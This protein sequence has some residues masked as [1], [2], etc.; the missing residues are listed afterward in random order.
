[1]RETLH[2]LTLALA[3]PIAVVAVG[4]FRGEPAATTARETANA[5]RV[6][7]AELPLP[8]PER[9]RTPGEAFD[10][11][12]PRVTPEDP[13]PSHRRRALPNPS[14]P[15]PVD[16]AVDAGA[17]IAVAAPPSPPAEPG[18]TGAEP[19][20]S[21]PPVPSGGPALAAAAPAATAHP[22]ALVPKVASSTVPVKIPA[23]IAATAS[24][25]PAQSITASSAARTVAQSTPAISTAKTVAQSIIGTPSAQLPV[26]SFTR[27]SVAKLP[28]QLSPGNP[29]VKETTPV[30]LPST[31][32][33]VAMF[34]PAPDFLPRNSAPTFSSGPVSIP[35][36]AWG[37]ANAFPILADRF[38][39]TE[40]WQEQGGSPNGHAPLTPPGLTDEPPFG[41]S[42][43]PDPPGPSFEVFDLPLPAVASAAA[44]GSSDHS[45][46]FSLPTLGLRWGAG[47]PITPVMIP[48]PG[49][50]LLLGAALAALGAAR[51]SRRRASAADSPR[52]Y[53]PDRS[54]A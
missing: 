6:E 54:T 46:D 47:M 8:T 17:G 15:S 22:R 44:H 52:S 29:V 42:L 49:S 12:A 26:Q 48:E 53:E 3:L 2:Q 25:V 34:D 16:L 36:H 23:K 19:S 24:E 10:W 32:K 18:L 31:P 4:T 21:L 14:A 13:T 28:V 45:V 7:L 51:R 11:R 9:L 33:P 50:A 41:L 37:A 43:K 27:T 20:A 39:V 38:G 40:S 35:G 30:V 1:M 5:Y